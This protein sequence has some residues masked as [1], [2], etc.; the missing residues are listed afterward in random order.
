M[1]LKSK[2][3]NKLV[4]IS[5]TL[6]VVFFVLIYSNYR[7]NNNPSIPD[8][9]QLFIKYDDVDIIEIENKLPVADALGKKFNGEGTEDGVQGY[10]ELSVKNITNKKVKYEVL[11]TKLPTDNMQ[12]SDN[13]IKI[14]L[15]NE[16]NSPL[17]GFDL[18]A[19]YS[20][21][22]IRDQIKALKKYELA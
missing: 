10:L 12:I 5:I 14:Y 7:K 15:T 11:G 2:R 3:A 20:S 18:N 21:H 13:Y 22:E 16:D 4:L 17:N 8:K 19:I 6:I 1:N 9:D